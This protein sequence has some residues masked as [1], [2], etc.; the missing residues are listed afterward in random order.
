MEISIRVFALNG[1]FP[2]EYLHPM[3]ISTGEFTLNGISTTVFALNGNF[4]YSN[5]I[6][7]KFSQV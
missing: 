3:E 5:C 1:K 6:E 7:L 4:H 2:M